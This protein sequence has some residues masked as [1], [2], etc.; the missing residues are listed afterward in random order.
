LAGGNL[1][2]AFDAGINHQIIAVV[3]GSSFDGR[4]KDIETL[5]STSI[6]ELSR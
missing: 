1:V 3:L 2:I 4:F 5:V 6:K